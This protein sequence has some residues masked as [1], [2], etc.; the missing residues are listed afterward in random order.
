MPESDSPEM[1]IIAASL[2]YP[3]V[4]AARLRLRTRGARGAM[5]VAEAERERSEALYD[6]E[7]DLLAVI[8]ETE[9]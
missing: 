1:R 3:V 4:R 9:L 6:R 2:A 5:Y 7:K 8:T